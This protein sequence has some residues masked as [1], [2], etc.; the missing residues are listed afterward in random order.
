[1]KHRFTVVEDQDTTLAIAVGAFLDCEHY[2]YLHR[3]IMASFE[4]LDY[5]ERKIRVRQRMRWMGML[6]GHECTIEYLPPGHFRTTDIVAS[7]RWVPSV[8]HI[9]KNTVV[10]IRYRRHPE[11]DTTLMRFDMQFDMPFWLYPLRS[12]LQAVLERMHHL[13]EEEDLRVFARR[14]RLFGRD[15][16]ACY[17]ADHQFLLHKDEYLRCF[18]PH[19]ALLVPENPEPD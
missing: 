7:P 15:N 19:S 13:K 18:G 2:V 12:Y 3:S 17:L 9:L 11:R 16:N 4:V 8:H 1:M 10:D 5:Q 14:A 6:I